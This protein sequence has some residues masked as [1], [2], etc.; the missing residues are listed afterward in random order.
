MDRLDDLRDVVAALAM[1]PHLDVFVG[2]R[3]DLVHT[4]LVLSGFCALAARGA[5][6]LRYHVPKGDAERWL[7]HDPIV[8]VFDIHAGGSTRV[9]IDL[10]DG[11]GI[12]QPAFDRV[13]WYFKRAFYPPETA[14][15]GPDASRKLLPFGLNYGCRTSGSAVRLLAAIGGPLALTGQAGLRR[16][17][18]YLQTPGPAAFE[19]T[20]DVPVEP[21]VAFQTR[22]WT[23]QEVAPGESQMLNPERVAMVRALKKEFG[24]RFVGGLVPTPFA[25]AHYPDDLTPHSS[26]YARYLALK[27]RCLISVYTRGVEHSLAFKLGETF[28]ASQCL[29]SVPLRY[30]L[31]EPLVSGCHYFEFESIDGCLAACHRLFADRE[32]AQSLRRANHDYYRREIEPAA[33]VRRVL[34]RVAEGETG[35]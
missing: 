11:E 33:H 3:H 28:A 13:Q 5:I 18:Q 32:L 25:K 14:A 30:Q 35:A 12:S 29:V 16:L 27:K 20:P 15:L 17:R 1:T 22:L 7:I 23:E 10:R 31:P 34:E 2:P 21:W 8:V 9:A 4:S 24:P 6:T 26:N 19:Q